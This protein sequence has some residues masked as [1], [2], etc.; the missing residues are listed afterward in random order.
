MA[1]EDVLR[2]LQ[3][4]QQR[5]PAGATPP[6]FVD[7][8]TGPHDGA[9]RHG[10]V[11]DRAR[12]GVRQR[13]AY[14]DRDV[15]APSAQRRHHRD[16]ADRCPDVLRGRN[17]R[18]QPPRSRPRPLRADLG[19]PGSRA[20][21]PCRR[22]VHPSR[23]QSVA[24]TGPTA[25]PGAHADAARRGPDEPLGA[26]HR[27]ERQQR[28]ALPVRALRPAALPLRRDRQLRRPGLRRGPDRPLER[29]RPEQPR[30]AHRR[31][32]RRHVPGRA[33]E[34]ARPLHRRSRG[35]RDLV[36]RGA[37]ARLRPAVRSARVHRD[38]RGRTRPRGRAGRPAG[39]SRGDVR[40]RR[41]RARLDRRRRS[42]RACADGA[43]DLA[44][45]SPR[46]DAE[47]GVGGV[48][49]HVDGPGGRRG[50]RRRAGPSART[51]AGSGCRPGRSGST[52]L[53]PTT[54]STPS[55][56]PHGARPAPA[57]GNDTERLRD[58][59]RGERRRAGHRGARGAPL[60]AAAPAAARLGHVHR[61]GRDRRA[62]D[63]RLQRAGR[64]GGRR[65]PR[66]DR[67]AEAR[68]HVRAGH[69]DAHHRDHAERGLLRRH[70]GARQRDEDA[71]DALH[72]AGGGAQPAG[73]RTRPPLPPGL[74]A[75]I[76]AAGRHRCR[77][78]R[79]RVRH[80]GLPPGGDRRSG[81]V[82]VRR[83]ATTSSPRATPSSPP[84]TRSCSSRTPAG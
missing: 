33:A 19:S 82:P 54:A 60:P 5:P 55:P 61:Q 58:R 78:R 41:R 2:S 84:P 37:G 10:P 76:R 75:P 46:R 30:R 57:R 38:V 31:P 50:R 4:L 71:A 24:R 27:R 36:G 3:G 40:Q 23:P 59:R 70:G 16:R 21:R 20:R 35:G 25:R 11:H 77:P 74:A 65:S 53:S 17:R 56:P 79:P 72:A 52:S 7:P 32:R 14:P 67:A 29:D 22:P 48:R 73:S 49:G 64:L 66:P 15:D 47:L 39:G 26:V 63:G 83:R 6:P 42:D 62:A 51:W 68:R 69:V 81:D 18:V 8:I 44:T 13:P 34:G 45:G 9:G 1:S 80:A 28:R 12:P 43:R